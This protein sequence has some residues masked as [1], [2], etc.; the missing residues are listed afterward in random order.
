MENY[1]LSIA[2]GI[3]SSFT[4]SIIFLFT[5]R[6][7]R[8]KIEVSRVI[9]RGIDLGSDTRYIIK[10]INKGRRSVINIRAELR[11]QIPSM[12]P[13][14]SSPFCTFFSLLSSFFKGCAT[15]GI[16]GIPRCLWCSFEHIYHIVI[17]YKL[18]APLALVLG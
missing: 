12:L 13:L 1:V 18:R 3:V 15:E 2:I 14:L 8:P 6:L 11:L 5:F 4:A 7:L 16:L 17:V 10:I 9:A